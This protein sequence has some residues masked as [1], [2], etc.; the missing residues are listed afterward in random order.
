[1]R[2]LLQAAL[3]ASLCLGFGVIIAKAQEAAAPERVQAK[4]PVLPPVETGP[5][6]VVAK[7]L[8]S[9]REGDDATAEALLSDRARIE[10]EKANLKVESPGTPNARFQVG[11]V[12]YVTERRDG[13]HVASVWE[14]TYADGSTE[15]YNVTWVLRKQ[16]NGFRIVGLATQPRPGAA[17]IFFNFENPQDMMQKIEQA[18]ADVAAPQGGSGPGSD[19]G[20]GSAP[21]RD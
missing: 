9:L 5:D 4:K 6:V 8:D 12:Q 16:E 17:E 7:F 21:A 13:A 2:R 18:N 11:T 3:A 10:T 20:D 15:R 14:D 1:M 19:L